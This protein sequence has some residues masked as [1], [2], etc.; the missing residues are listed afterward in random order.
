MKNEYQR[1]V[2]WSIFTRPN[3]SARVPENRPPRDEISSV[4]VPMRP[5][6]PRDNPH[7]EITV[8]ITKLFIWTSNASR[9]QLPPM[10]AGAPGGGYALSIWMPT[11]LRT[12][13][14]LSSEVFR[15]LRS[16][17]AATQPCARSLMSLASDL[18]HLWLR[19]SSE[20]R[21]AGYALSV[22]LGPGR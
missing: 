20:C 5:A 16:A 13:R 6:S 1:M 22:I 11:Y 14:G 4:T 19:R 21:N 12:V 17:L 10:V 7:N 3:L 8:G 18:R 15:S 2:I 9:D